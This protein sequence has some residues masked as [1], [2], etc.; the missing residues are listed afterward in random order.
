MERENILSP[1]PVNNF[2][3]C[4]S[5][6]RLICFTFKREI[7][8]NGVDVISLARKLRVV[9]GEEVLGLQASQR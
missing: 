5:Q 7:C 6:C 4:I 8:D 3:N 9:K 2:L 1:P